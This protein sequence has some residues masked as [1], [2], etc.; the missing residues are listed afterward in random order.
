MGQGVTAVPH[1]VHRWPSATTLHGVPLRQ[2]ASISKPRL[3]VC[4]DVVLEA[5]R[6]APQTVDRSK[7][8]GTRLWSALPVR[9]ACHTLATKIWCGEGDRK[10]SQCP[11]VP[12]DATTT[13]SC[14]T[15]MQ[16]VSSHHP[17]YHFGNIQVYF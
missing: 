5:A 12:V 14:P 13:I 10:K 6:S 7:P 16:V 4:H 8:E 17:I 2:A 9:P 1:V 3:V 11:V 15:T